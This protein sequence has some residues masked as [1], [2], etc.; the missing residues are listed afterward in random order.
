MIELIPGVSIVPSLMEN[1]LLEKGLI[2]IVSDFSGTFPAG[3]HPHDA[4]YGEIK[5]YE[6]LQDSE[7]KFSGWEITFQAGS[8]LKINPPIG[9]LG[10][11]FSSIDDYSHLSLPTT[12]IQNVPDKPGR[13]YFRYEIQKAFETEP[14]LRPIF[15]FQE[16]LK[17]CL[18]KA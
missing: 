5:R 14:L 13:I 11:Y 16:E 9:K 1:Q 4:E 2:L 18:Y 7:G 6:R 8:M 3:A 10:R 15:A 17:R 12:I